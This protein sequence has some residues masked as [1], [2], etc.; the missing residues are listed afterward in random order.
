MSTLPLIVFRILKCLKEQSGN[1]KC[2]CLQK[3]TCT[4][5]GICLY[6]EVTY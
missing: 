1:P 3:N 2:N 6:K 4:L 5:D